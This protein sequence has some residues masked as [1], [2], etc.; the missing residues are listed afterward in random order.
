MLSTVLVDDHEV[1]RQG[2]RVLLEQADDCRVVGEAADGLSAVAMI[3]ELKPEIAVIDVQL[4]DLNGI[5]VARRVHETTPAT[6]IIVLSMYSDELFVLD[7]LR[8]GVSAYVLKSSAAQDLISAVHTVNSGGRFLSAPLNA[9][10]IDQY[11]HTASSPRPD[12]DR[13]ELLTGREREVL[14]LAAQGQTNQQ[15][16]DRLAISPRT[17]E[18]HRSNISRKLGFRNQLDLIRFAESRK[19]IEPPRGADLP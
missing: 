4:P 17:A 18:T 9:R 13:Y 10:A 12:V 16:A 2:V 1:V 11:V 15:I 7:A 5:E 6:R 8:H 19:L 14:Q 3:E